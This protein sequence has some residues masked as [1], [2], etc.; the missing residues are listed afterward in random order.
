M[1]GRDAK[2]K[3][4]IIHIDERCVRKVGV[5][6]FVRWPTGLASQYIFVS[7]GYLDKSRI[8]IAIHKLDLNSTGQ[9]I[10]RVGSPLEVVRVSM[11]P[12]QV[13]RKLIKQTSG[14]RALRVST[15]SM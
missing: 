14:K 10:R 2:V 3:L 5:S 9:R 11:F 6:G 15:H 12:C 8:T 1:L 13:R 7:G 4:Q